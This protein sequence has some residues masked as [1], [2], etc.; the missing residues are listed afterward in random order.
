MNTQEILNKMTLEQKIALCSGAD[1]WTTKEMPSLGIPALF[2]CDGPHGLRKQEQVSDILGINQSRPST[3]FPPAVTTASTWDVSLLE[4][5]GAAIGEEARNQKVGMVLGPG[6]NI[7]RNPL[8]GRNFEYFSEDPYL[9]GK[10]AAAFVRGVEGKGV[11]TSLKHFACNSQENARLVSDGVMDERTLREIYLPAFE[12]AVKQ[13]KPSTLMCSY[14]KLNGVHLSDNKKMLT[15]IL[16]DE[17]GFEGAVITDW[18]AMNDRMEGFRAGCDLNMPG[19]SA[20]MEKECLQAVK[21]GTLSEE[22]I[23]RCAA[24]V[25]KLIMEKTHAMT[26]ED[27]DYDAHNALAEEAALSG[28]VLLKNNDGLL[29]LK[30]ESRIAVIGS[31]AKNIR[32]Q[33]AGSSHINPITLSQPLDLFR[34][35]AYAPGCD[36]AGNTTPELLSEVRKASL[37]ADAVV[38]FAGLPDSYESEGYDRKDMRMP[39]GHLKMISEAVEANPNTVVVLLC[40][41]PV[42]CPWADKV[43]SVLYVGLPGQAGAGAIKKLLYGDAVPCGRLAESWPR[44]YGDVP[45]SDIFGSRDA[46]YEEGIYVGYRYYDKA[47]IQPRWAFG[48]GLSYTTFAYSDLTVTPGTACVKVKNSGTRDG[49]E[50]VM[51]YVKAPQTGLHRPQRELKGFEKIFLKAGEEKVVTFTLNDRSYAVYDNGWKVPAGHYEIC[52]GPL[53]AAVKVEGVT[54]AAPSWQKGSFYESCGKKPTRTE[55]ERMLGHAY[56]PAPA[57]KKGSYTTENTVEEMARDS[58]VMKTVYAAVAFF[59]KKN[60]KTKD[61]NDPE[62]KMMMEFSL[63]SPYRSMYMSGRLKSGLFHGLLEIANGHYLKGIRSIIKG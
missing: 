22:D 23:D 49:S 59:L 58:L 39:E 63:R 35:C 3:C 8:C 17:W 52:V 61:P 7:K 19:G 55:W 30:K 4:R 2:M 33:G 57:A 15:D 21:D 37:E 20:Y 53:S 13:G 56:T 51:L 38:V 47:G 24:R 6:V 41:S 9:A 29:P 31:M 46:L 45:S 28:A 27:C 14:P 16:R 25:L 1:F 11:G 54:L 43:K 42:E 36:E 62:L 60:L 48:H 50:V 10:L 34:G 26:G 40:G 44:E 12:E 5:I 32:Y 18:G